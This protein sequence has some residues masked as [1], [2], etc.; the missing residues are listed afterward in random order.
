MSRRVWLL[1]AFAAFLGLQTSLCTYACLAEEGEAPA[2]GPAHGP[3]AD[4]H[5]GSDRSESPANPSPPHQGCGC[6]DDATAL[7]A[8]NKPESAALA[9]AA[10]ISFAGPAARSAAKLSPA[11]PG[12]PR[13]PPLD[14]LLLKA[15]LLL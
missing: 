7:L 5:C 10:A 3:P 4:P 9:G 2:A 6:G 8:K 12:D 13:P 11:R 15:A 14:L 1:F